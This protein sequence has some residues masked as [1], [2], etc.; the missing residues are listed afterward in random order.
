MHGLDIIS[1]LLASVINLVVTF[2]VLLY[3][4]Y[5]LHIIYHMLLIC[6]LIKF[7]LRTSLF[8]PWGGGGTVISG[9]QASRLSVTPLQGGC[10]EQCADNISNGHTCLNP[11]NSG[12]LCVLGNL[13][14][15]Q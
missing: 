5:I 4:H 7:M 2:I 3:I 11:P 15:S 9:V 10:L 1:V 6:I 8:S 14:G 13:G 12:D